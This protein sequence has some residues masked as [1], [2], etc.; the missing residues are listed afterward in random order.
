MHYLLFFILLFGYSSTAY[1]ER[2]DRSELSTLDLGVSRVYYNQDDINHYEMID[3]YVQSFSRFVQN[4]EITQSSTCKD[5]KI[6][7]FLLDD[8]TI[9]SR[10]SMSFLD[11]DSWGNKNIW[12]AYFRVNSENRRE[13]FLNTS[14]T[15]EK[16]IE[17]SFHELYHWYQDITCVGLSENPARD[18][19]REMCKLNNQC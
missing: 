8:A 12:G 7:V 19:S 9:N 15:R 5:V 18:F 13:L 11:W 16:F 10:E 4:V 3:I 6:E 17:S 2:F 1:A 14:A